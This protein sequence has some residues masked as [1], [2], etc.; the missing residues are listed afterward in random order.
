MLP[1][2][3]DASATRVGLVGAG[4]GLQ[5]R[6]GMIEEADAAGHSLFVLDDHDVTLHCRWGHAVRRLP[7][8]DEIAEL[9]VLFI[10]GLDRET[11]ARLAGEARAL[12]VLVNVEDVPELCDFH[13]P[14]SVRRGSLLLTVSTGG[15]APGLASVV[16]A[17]LEDRFGPEWVERTEELAAQRRVWRDE[18]LAPREIATRT[19]ALVDERK[20]LR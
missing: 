14:A 12:G 15:R 18:R 16:R 8:R 20:W 3:L 1:I 10:A 13:V 2:V 5:N 11:S 19:A 9:R 6:L 4:Q 7:R 17:E